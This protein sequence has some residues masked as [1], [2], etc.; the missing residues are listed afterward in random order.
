MRWVNFFHLYQP[1]HWNEDIIRQVAAEAYRPMLRILSDHPHIRV[2]LNISGALTEQLL[3]LG[4]EDVVDGWRAAIERHQIELVG[5]A[6]YHP[7]L[8]LIHPE[9]V[10]RQIEL[11]EDLHRRVFGS[12]YRPKGFYAP[13]MAFDPRLEPVLLDLG[14]RWIILDEVALGRMGQAVFPR[15][16]RLA[17]GLGVVVRNRPISDY[18]SFSAQLDQLDTVARALLADARSHEAL[19][20]AMDGE[21]LGHH[22]HGVDR[23]WEQLVT[24]PDVVPQT[25]SDYLANCQTHEVIELAPSSWSSQESELR[26][27][28]P[29]GLWSHP[30]NPIHKLQWE[31]LHLVRTTVARSINDDHYDAA[32]R[33][34]DRA[35]T[36]DKFWWA[37]ASPWWDAAIVIRETQ[38]LAD[39]IGPLA[40][41]TPAAKRGVAKLMDQLTTTVELWERTGL[42]RRRQ[43]AYLNETGDVRY[44]GG[45]QV[46]ASR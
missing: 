42:A 8:P 30:A 11:Q 5:S 36:S 17:G 10:R 28:I 19:V 9:E 43:R 7:I 45:Q 33:L 18:L 40:S 23:M 44:M 14:F 16:Y 27:N 41:A 4:L 13:E 21:N 12:L 46:T 29:F 31:L 32:R 39:V 35:L 38:R 2:T 37:S 6:M 3:E 20:T 26:H 22:R 15:G 25:V 34:L 24:R 1:P